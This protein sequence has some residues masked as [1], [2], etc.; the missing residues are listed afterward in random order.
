MQVNI[1]K[2]KDWLRIQLSKQPIPYSLC[3]QRVEAL[4]VL[5][6]LRACTEQQALYEGL[7]LEL[8]PQGVV[9]PASPVA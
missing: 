1:K 8:T 3:H 5:Q 6:A 2:I 9:V 7:G 4:P